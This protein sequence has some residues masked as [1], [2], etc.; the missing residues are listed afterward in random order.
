MGNGN[1]EE[2]KCPLVSTVKGTI[3]P[4]SNQVSNYQGFTDRPNSKIGCSLPSKVTRVPDNSLTVCI[5]LYWF[6]RIDLCYRVP[7]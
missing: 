4:G 3:S 2:G 6:K 1:K 7:Q 5:L